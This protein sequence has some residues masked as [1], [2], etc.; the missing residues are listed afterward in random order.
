MVREAE[1]KTTEMTTAAG[2][3]TFGLQKEDQ[4]PRAQ[5]IILLMLTL[6]VK[7]LMLYVLLF[8]LYPSIHTAGIQIL[9]QK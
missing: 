5:K 6:A 9:G 8:A 3:E 2:V 1:Q 4:C 7:A